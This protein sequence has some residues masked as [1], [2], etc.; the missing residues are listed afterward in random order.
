MEKNQILQESLKQLNDHARA[1]LSLASNENLFELASGS[2]QDYDAVTINSSADPAL[3]YKAFIQPWAP[4]KDIN[5]LI[6]HMKSMPASTILLA[7]FVN[8]VMAEKFRRRSLSF[9]DCAGNLSIKNERFNFYVKGK[10]RPHFRARHVRGRAFNS[11]GLKLIFAIFNQPEL[12]HSTYREISSKVNIAL[13]SV[14]PVMDDL[15]TSGYILDDG[16]RRLVN[17]KRLFERWVDGYLEKL[18]PK[19]ILS[20]C[21]ADNED[22]WKQADPEAFDGLWG[23]EVT[24]AKS[25]PFMMPETI[26]LYFFSDNKHEEFV[27]FYGLQEDDEGDICIYKTFWSD[28]AGNV[29]GISPMVMYADI[30]DSINPGA[31]D[32]AKTFYGEAVA[33]LLDD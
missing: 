19:Q 20:C 22:W 9:V 30:V 4:Q 7:N 31:W 11:A 29:G 6:M 14:G 12:L 16:Q 10:K 26:S 5:T 21:R 32:V 27:D 24:I 8:P 18:R 1:E 33:H 2:M 25:T 23:G 17:K 13:G 28:A 15:F 3:S